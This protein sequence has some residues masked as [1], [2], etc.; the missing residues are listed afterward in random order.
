MPEIT[1]CLETGLKKYARSKTFDG[2][3]NVL[4]DLKNYCQVNY[5]YSIDAGCNKCIAKW[6]NRIIIDRNI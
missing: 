6:M 4:R 2:D 3:G 1:E 5:Q